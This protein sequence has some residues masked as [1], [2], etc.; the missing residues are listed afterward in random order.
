MTRFH[1]STAAYYA[2]MSVISSGVYANMDNAKPSVYAG[3]SLQQFAA[4]DALT[5]IERLPS[6]TLIER[7]G[8]RGLGGSSANI[9]LN[10]MEIRVKSGSVSKY[11]KQLPV[12][13]IVA[14]EVYLSHHPFPSLKQYNQVVNIIRDEKT[15][16]Y[17]WQLGSAINASASTGITAMAGFALPIE[18]WTH[19]GHIQV[20][21]EPYKSTSQGQLFASSNTLE[22]KSEET[23]K[24][25]SERITLSL[26]SHK[27]IQDG[28]LTLNVQAVKDNLQSQYEWLYRTPTSS[29]DVE[30]AFSQ[31]R[32]KTNTSEMS[33][34]R[35][36]QGQRW[37]TQ[38]T[39]YYSKQKNE[40]HMLDGLSA[41][42][43]T[44]SF[45][46]YKRTDERVIRLMVND[47]VSEYG[48]EASINRVN[49]NTLLPEEQLHS[50]IKELSF[51]PF[52]AFTWSLSPKWRLYSKLAAEQATLSTNSSKSE[53][54][55]HLIAKPLV[56]LNYDATKHIQLTA[57]L[58]HEV[59][60]LDF[61]LFLPELNAGFGRLQFGNLEIEPMQYTELALQI[62]IEEGER[63]RFNVKP[64]YQW[65]KDVHEYQQD[66]RGESIVANA[67]DAAL[68]GLDGAVNLDLSSWINNSQL[69]LD[70]SYRDAS[71]RDALTGKRAINGTVPHRA[72]VQFRQSF[73]RFS[74]SAEISSGDSY[75]EYYPD[76]QFIEAGSLQLTL[77]AQ[78]QVSQ[79]VKL[80]LEASPLTS[81]YEYRRL[82]YNTSRADSVSAV[83]T[84]RE[85][86][87][88][89]FAFTLSGSW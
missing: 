85:R 37:S 15:N 61:S 58:K 79:Q 2:L 6:F 70:Y 54:I 87:P 26:T 21:D 27:T 30:S 32:D 71:Y 64:F 18:Q 14:L 7:S 28:A 83:E 12:D 65:Q 80:N 68:W 59:E 11:L 52:A 55:Q 62:D 57:T 36:W 17:N 42:L 43:S 4:Q 48:L 81:R 20:Q 75:R 66:N 23:F 44:P 86:V 29:S 72:S 51:E 22:E 25:Q 45:T 24:E 39:G 74:W 47:A 60:Q 41:Q 40:L 33:I 77:Q 49:A 31:E 5:A 16:A 46:Q 3:S 38:L 76:E 78:L 88:P 19:S 69:N 10:G 35:Q 89:E 73:N 34:D 1:P 56:R 53:D 63:W 13:Q 50:T 67:G 82:Y 84:I 9:L 8:E